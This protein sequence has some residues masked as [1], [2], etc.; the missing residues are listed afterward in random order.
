MHEAASQVRGEYDAYIA[1]ALATPGGHLAVGRGGATLYFGDGW[2]SGCHPEEIKAACIAAGLPVIDS[3]AVSF[4]AVYGLAVRGPMIA[5]N[6][7][8]GPEPWGALSYA[9]L[10]VVAEAYRAAGAEVFNL[11]PL[12]PAQ[13]AESERVEGVP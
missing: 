12:S 9:P 13:A 11:G 4:E 5:V 2:L 3:R 1:R 6:R 8:P 7:E 10:A